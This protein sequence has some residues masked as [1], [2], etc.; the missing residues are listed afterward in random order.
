MRFDELRLLTT[1]RPS[2]PVK[3]LPA[4]KA[5]RRPDWPQHAGFAVFFCNIP[6]INTI[7][8]ILIF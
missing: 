1:K 8:K 6:Q 7:C 2:L 5:D 3:P 4:E